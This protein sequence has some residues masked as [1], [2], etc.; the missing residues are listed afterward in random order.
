MFDVFLWTAIEAMAVTVGV[1]SGV[2]VVF[3]VFVYWKSGGGRY[4]F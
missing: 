1:L 4:G 2:I 3:F